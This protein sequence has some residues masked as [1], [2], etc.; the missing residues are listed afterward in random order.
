MKY[1][2]KIFSDN[3]MNAK[4][5]EIIFDRLT[6]VKTPFKSYMIDATKFEEFTPIQP[7]EE[8]EEELLE[9]DP[10]EEQF[11]APTQPS[12]TSTSES[13]ADIPQNKVSGINSYGS[14]VTANNEAIKALGPNPHSIDMIEAGFRT[15]T[16]RSESEMAKYAIKVGD[17]IKHFGKSADGST[18]TVY[19]KVTAI[20]PKGSEG[21]K[22]TWNKEGW[23]A[24]DVNV[25]D[26]FKDGAAAIEFEVIQP[27]SQPTVEPVEEVKLGVSEVFESNPELSSIGTPEQYSKYLDTIFPDSQ[28]KD[29]VYHGASAQFDKFNDQDDI[30]AFGSGAIFLADLN[31]A[32][33]FAGLSSTLSGSPVILPVI[34]NIKNPLVV[35]DVKFNRRR[36]KP[37]WAPPIGTQDARDILNKNKDNDGLIGID[38]SDMENTT[39][40]VRN[41]DQTHILGTKQDI[42]GFKNFITQPST[43]P[44]E[45]IDKF[46]KKNIFTVTPIQAADK[47]AKIKASIATQYIGFGEGIVGKDGKRSSTQLYREQVGALAN[48]G[49]Y[50]SDDVIFVSVPGLRGDATIAKREQDKTIKEAI[51]AIEAGATI[52]T[53]NKA[54]TDAN[55]YNTGEQRLYANMEAKGYNYS[56]IT[57]DGQVIGTWSKS[58][59]PIEASVPTGVQEFKVGDRVTDKQTGQL[60]IITKVD[61]AYDPSNPE[62]NFVYVDFQNGDS[63]EIDTRDLVIFTEK[64]DTEEDDSDDLDNNCTNPFLGE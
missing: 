51:K 56:E 11:K 27:V 62:L 54:Y 24:E 20:H 8:T 46:A 48:T 17:T 12:T 37:G 60:G 55:N 36:L 10:E 2:S 15:R 39:H 35:S 9:L 1:A 14:T 49:N 5:F 63:F 3:Y 38:Y 45:G 44:T 52:L 42:E 18:K 6:A 33:D 13:V 64:K 28:I 40:V 34:I 43:Q 19:A 25:I 57:V 50:S 31:Y 59:Q 30:E 4:T 29:I 61:V 32:K 22:G 21:W 7:I 16:T 53:D 23:R 47:K 41:S 58:T 26:R